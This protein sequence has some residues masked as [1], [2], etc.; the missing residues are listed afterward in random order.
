[1]LIALALLPKMALFKDLQSANVNLIEL[2]YEAEKA[3]QS[4]VWKKSHIHATDLREW[5][6]AGACHEGV[7]FLIR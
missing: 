1:M 7:D 6:K 2:W 3:G 5:E 4:N